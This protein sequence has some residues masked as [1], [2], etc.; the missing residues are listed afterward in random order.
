MSVVRKRKALKSYTKKVSSRAKKTKSGGYSFF[1]IA[2]WSILGVIVV[3]MLTVAL[4]VLFTSLT[5]PEKVVTL[6][7]EAITADYYENYFYDR[8]KDYDNLDKYTESG[9]SR[10]ALRQLLL[11]DS[12]RHAD[13][14]SLISKYCDTDATYV[15]IYPEAPFSKTDYHVDYHYACTF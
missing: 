7:I 9:F 6:K 14:M 11:F 15:R 12:E 13:D 4:L 8:I 2:R 1:S 5:N 10:V 3:A